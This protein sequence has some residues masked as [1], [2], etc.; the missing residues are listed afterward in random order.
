M[1]VCLDIQP[2][3]TQTAGVGRYVRELAAHLPAFAAADQLTLFWFDFRRRGQPPPVTGARMRPHRWLPGRWVQQAW[4]RLDWPP[5]QWFAGRADVYHFPNFIIPPLRRGRAVVTIHD[6]SFIHF[7]DAAEPKNLA[8]LTARIGETVR[9]AEA[10][11]ADSAAIAA[12]IIEHFHIPSEK[13]IAIPL[14]IDARF[15]PPSADGIT[16]VRARHNLDRPYLLMVGT[17][18]PRKNIPFL[19]DVFERLKDFDGELI[20][21]GRPGWKTETIYARIA[22][23]P[24]AA[25]IRQLTGVADDDLPAL[26]AGAQVLVYPSLYEGFGFPPLEAMACGTPV[27]SSPHGSLREILGE[28]AAI[29]EEFDAELWAAHVRAA[30]HDTEWRRRAI[31]AGRACAARYRWEDTARRTWAVYRQV[32]GAA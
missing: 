23:S 7:P 24:R 14:G 12:E 21:V 25:R 18:E 11:I 8:Y 29:V 2:A 13:V 28:A 30:I 15:A 32:A 26:Y 9:R 10:I 27:V 3:V 16:A 19:I 5:F 20:L 1:R 17:I 4:K 31:E 6:L 22:C